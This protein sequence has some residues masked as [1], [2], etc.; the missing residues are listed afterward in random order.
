MNTTE[1]KEYTA[2]KARAENRKEQVKKYFARR[3]IRFQAYKTFFEKTATAEQK[4]AL[5]E[6]LKN[7]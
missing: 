3:A 1:E 5:A 2:L 4:N 6:S 7:I